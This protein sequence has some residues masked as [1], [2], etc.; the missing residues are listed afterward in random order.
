[1]GRLLNPADR[2]MPKGAGA[3]FL[4]CIV[5]WAAESTAS[6]VLGLQSPGGY[7]HQRDRACRHR[8]D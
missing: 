4:S 7:A 8:A 6:G 2:F 1:M 3:L 5:L